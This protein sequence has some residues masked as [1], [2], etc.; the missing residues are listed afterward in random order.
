MGE[1]A[2][3]VGAVGRT[4]GYFHE[5]H[6]RILE[7]GRRRGFIDRQ[8]AIGRRSVQLRFVGPTLVAPL[9]RALA[10]LGS[11]STG[12]PAL[13]V[14]LAAGDE[15]ELPPPPW[16]LPRSG[17]RVEPD[18]E[19]RRAVHLRD[20]RVEGLLEVDHGAMSLFD[21]ASSVGLFWTVSPERLAYYE[22]GAPLRAI[23]FW[24]GLRHGWHMAHAGG[25]G[26]DGGGVLL[27]GKGGSGKSTAALACLGAGLDYLGDNDVMIEAEPAPFAHGLYCSAK[28]EAGHLRRALPHLSSFLATAGPW[29]GGKGLFYVDRGAGHRL[30]AGFPLRAVLLPRVTGT[31]R[32]ITTRVSA[33]HGLLSLAPSTLFQLP[34]ARQERL[35]HLARVVKRVPTYALELGT[36]LDTIAPAILGLLAD[37]PD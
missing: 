33:A 36:N 32:T 13:T 27:V 2:H 20:E 18:E 7:A 15:V 25:V 34:G 8:Y 14:Y 30:S 17:S 23:F 22:R 11:D 6:A 19:T 16:E 12:E 21:T 31:P 37:K 26:T 9:T 3:G 29:K 5:L 35:S 24:W 28:L 4:A 1:S 10:H